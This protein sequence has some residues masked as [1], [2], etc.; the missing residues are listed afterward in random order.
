MLEIYHSIKLI[1]TEYIASKYRDSNELNIANFI[2]W[3]NEETNDIN[4]EEKKCQICSKSI[5]D[6]NNEDGSLISEL[7]PDLVRNI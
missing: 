6:S 5:T 1:L 2:M 3:S 7:F 4:N